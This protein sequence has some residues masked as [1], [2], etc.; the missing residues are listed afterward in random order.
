MP[1]AITDLMWAVVRRNWVEAALIVQS[2]WDHGC[3]RQLCNKILHKSPDRETCDL[4]DFK[5]PH[6]TV[7]HL[8]SHD[9]PTDKS[10]PADH[11]AYL[12]IW[13]VVSAVV[14]DHAAIDVRQGIPGDGGKIALQNAALQNNELAMCGL[15]AVGAGGL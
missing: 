13:K 3:F 14:K 7:L 11:D 4:E 5:I 8:L 1:V 6:T 15:L 12:Y 10:P 9:G 2:C